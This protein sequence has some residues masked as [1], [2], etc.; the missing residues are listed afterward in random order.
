MSKMTV[1]KITFQKP[2][3]PPQNLVDQARLSI[4]IRVLKRA[5]EYLEA[6]V[7]ILERKVKVLE[8]KNRHKK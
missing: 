3:F 2:A 6:R 7:L 4:T 1:G 5:Y 8:K